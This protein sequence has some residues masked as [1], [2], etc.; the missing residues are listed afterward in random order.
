MSKLTERA[1]ARAESLAAIM[2]EKRKQDEQVR[3]NMK[4]LRDLRTN[5]ATGDNEPDRLNT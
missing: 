3:A 2:Q 1:R 4:R 5:Y